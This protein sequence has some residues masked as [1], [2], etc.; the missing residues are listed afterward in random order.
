MNLPA[1]INH[2][3]T[4][5]PARDTIR[6][7]PDQDQHKKSCKTLQNNTLSTHYRLV[8][9][10][11]RPLGGPNT[12]LGTTSSRIPLLVVITWRSSSYR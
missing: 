12:L 7:I 9:L 2:D 10:H 8:N 11:C 5:L 6:H 3:F 4:S 1:H